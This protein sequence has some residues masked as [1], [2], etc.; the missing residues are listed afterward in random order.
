MKC[1]GSFASGMYLPTADMDLVVVSDSF[2]RDGKPFVYQPNNQKHRLSRSLIEQ[3]VAEPGTVTVV[4][5]AKVPIIKF[6]DQRTKIKVDISFENKTGL[7]A[8]ETFATWKTQYPAMPPLVLL[9]KQLLLMRG[10]NEV[11]N[12]GL[13]GFSIIC[14]VVS[15]IHNMPEIQSGNM[16]P[17]QHYGDLLLRFLDLYGNKFDL[18]RTGMVMDPPGYFDKIRYPVRKQNADGLTIIDPNKKDNDI[19]GGSRNIKQVFNCF[20]SAQ[21]AIQRRL[22]QIDSGE[23]VALRVSGSEFAFGCGPRVAYGRALTFS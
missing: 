13:G 9:V 6:V 2:M 16:V 18:R 17:E 15:M 3:G 7:I 20:R 10:L 5:H 11:F 8:N 22:A 19:S 1:F 4:T 23:C 14:L 21:A 12:G